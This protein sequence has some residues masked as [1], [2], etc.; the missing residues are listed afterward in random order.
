M[1]ESFNMEYAI[2]IIKNSEEYEFL[3]NSASVNEIDLIAQTAVNEFLADPRV[4][5]QNIDGLKL[6]QAF[7]K[8]VDTAIQNFLVYFYKDFY[9]DYF[10]LDVDREGN[11]IPESDRVFD[12]IKFEQ[13]IHFAVVVYDSK[14][15]LDYSSLGEFLDHFIVESINA[16]PN[17]SEMEKEGAVACHLNIVK[18]Q[19]SLLDNS[20]KGVVMSNSLFDDLEAEGV[21]ALMEAARTY[22]KNIGNTFGVYAIPCVRNRL[23]KYIKKETAHQKNKKQP[24]IFA[25]EE[26]QEVFIPD[27]SVN[28]EHDFVTKEVIEILHNAIEMLDP[29]DQLIIRASYGLDGETVRTQESMIEIFGVSQS[30]IS[31]KKTSVLTK[32]RSILSESGVNDLNF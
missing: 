24:S 17:L 22:K 25:N 19:M 15:Y 8:C 2:E 29:D 9:H 10:L 26:Q 31:K 3:L 30:S 28:I 6:T 14:Y 21:R 23:I 4:G 5:G 18:K 16:G 13:T 20:P 27:Q 1:N 7:I 11:I 32:L 12:N